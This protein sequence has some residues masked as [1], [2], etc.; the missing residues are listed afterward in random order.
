[1]ARMEMPKPTADHRK[2]EVFVG[3]WEGEETLFP[4]PWSPEERSATGRFTAR[5][6]MGG[7]F[8]ITDYEEERDGEIVFRGHGV[9]GWDPERERHTMHW[10]DSMG[11]APHET[12]G[13]W[14]GDT[15]TYEASSEHGKARYVY[16]VHD[17]DSYTFRIRNSADGTEWSTL[18]EGTYRRV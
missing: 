15:L 1:M 14:E 5:M 8:L 9:Y 3:E 17:A 16:E 7:M 6:G 4:S 18:M 2:L 10:F 12:L 11:V 13:R